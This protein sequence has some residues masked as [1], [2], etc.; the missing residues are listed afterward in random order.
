MR[1]LSSFASVFGFASL[2]ASSA[3]AQTPLPNAT[4]PVAT[5]APAAAS[6][7]VGQPITPAPGVRPATLQPEAPPPKSSCGPGAVQGVYPADAQTGVWLVCEEVRRRQGLPLAIS[8]N[9][10]PAAYRV[11]MLRLGNAVI[12]TLQVEAPIGTIRDGRQ[13]RLASIEELPVAA[14]RLV[15]ALWRGV[16]V[17][18]TQKVSNL[19][20]EETREYQKK[21]GEFLWGGG[22]MGVYG[23]GSSVGV[24][25]GIDI[26][27]GYETE[28]YGIGL[29]LRFGTGSDDHDDKSMDYVAFGIGGRYFLSD[30]NI[31]PFFGGGLTWSGIDVR[32]DDLGN[33]YGVSGSGMGAYGEVGVEFLRLHSSRLTFDLRFETPFYQLETDRYSYNSYYDAATD[34]YVNEAPSDDKKYVVPIMAG[35]TYTW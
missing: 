30:G 24:Q 3:L 21:P 25:P 16:P 32:S 17:T 2:I 8:P 14:P 26:R 22:L 34:S 20:G 23:A 1:H 27:A 9:E 6:A 13:L 12:L 18:S 10:G 31:G 11:G 15:D 5:P 4:E 7:P 19:V 35:L 28:K 29:D 33:G